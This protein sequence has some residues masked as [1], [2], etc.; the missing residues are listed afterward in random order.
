[1]LGLQTW[2]THS[3]ILNMIKSPYHH[4]QDWRH[5]SVYRSTCLTTM[6]KDLDLIRATHKFASKPST[7]EAEPEGS[8]HP[9]LYSKLEASLGYMRPC[10]RNKQMWAGE[11]AEQIK[12][13]HCSS[14]ELKL[15]FQ[16]PCQVAPT[17]LFELHFQGDP[18]SLASTGMPPTPPSPPH[19]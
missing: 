16:H 18:M 11:V 10:P 7:P 2:T 5:G 14:R 8:A 12:R 13:K 15:S 6:N 9:W 1:M 17:Q 4:Y 19:T 3:G